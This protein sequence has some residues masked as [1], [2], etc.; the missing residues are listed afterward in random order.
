MKLFRFI[1]SQQVKL[2]RQTRSVEKELETIII[3]AMIRL[4]MILTK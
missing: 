1:C 4:L 3:S 2:I